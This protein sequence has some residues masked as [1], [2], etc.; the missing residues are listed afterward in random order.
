[1][2]PLA[3]FDTE[4]TKLGSDRRIWDIGLILRDAPH[5][6]DREV[7]IIIA[8]V[9]LS[10]A[11]PFSLDIGHF[12]DRH[13]YYAASTLLPDG[14]ELLDE[15]DAAH[16]LEVA[17]R[18]RHII[19]LV[20]DFDTSGGADMLRRHCLLW[21]AHYQLMDAENLIV[22]YMAGRGTRMHPPWKT[23]D[24]SRMVG[25]EPPAADQRHT[26]LGD[27]RWVRDIWDVIMAEPATAAGAVVTRADL[28]LNMTAGVTT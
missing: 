14:T 7:S 24:L 19:G 13:P 8:D 28:G 16:R 1:M 21:N 20:P 6:P 15:H 18:G 2:T 3:F 12:Y 4:T 23:E 22:G 11:D 9:D 27:A 5:V 26:A 17:V 25:V 10:S